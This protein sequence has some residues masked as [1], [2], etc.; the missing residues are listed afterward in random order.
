MVLTLHKTNLDTMTIL[1]IMT[2][3]SFVTRDNVAQVQQL[4]AAGIH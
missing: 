3:T 4:I 2:C 1:I